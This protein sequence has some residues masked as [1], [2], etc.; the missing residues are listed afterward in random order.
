VLQVFDDDDDDLCGKAGANMSHSTVEKRRRDRINN[1]IDMLSERVPPLSSKYRQSN[2]TGERYC[3]LPLIA[4]SGIIKHS[5]KG[6]MIRTSLALMSAGVRRPKHIVLSDTLSLLSKIKNTLQGYEHKVARL[7][8]E[9]ESATA[10]LAKAMAAGPEAAAAAS[11]PTTPCIFV[12][13]AMSSTSLARSNKD[14]PAPKKPHLMGAQA[15]YSD[16]MNRQNRQ[17]CPSA[18]LPLLGA[19]KPLLPSVR[20][21]TSSVPMMVAHSEPAQVNKTQRM[22]VAASQPP[23]VLELHSLPY[24][25]VQVCR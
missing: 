24:V 17:Q 14:E 12:P 22:L 10:A 18:V 19:P 13:K 21:A 2:S 15:L 3:A 5:D 20:N 9:A 23:P 25:S 8:A 16:V 11:Y 1:L 7:T 4:T 6:W